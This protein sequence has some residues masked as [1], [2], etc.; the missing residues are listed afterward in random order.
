[1]NV[2]VLETQE[3]FESR[4]PR[5]LGCGYILPADTAEEGE[6]KPERIVHLLYQIP[7]RICVVSGPAAIRT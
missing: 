4:E 2:G 3:I 6:F 7:L 1:M 5:P